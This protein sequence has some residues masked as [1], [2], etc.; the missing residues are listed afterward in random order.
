VKLDLTSCLVVGISSRALFDLTEANEIFDTKGLQA[1]RH[2]QRQ[3]EDD[4]LGQG[5]A[6]PLVKALLRLNEYSQQQRLVEVIV[7]SRNSPDTG[8][9]ILNSIKHYDLDIT[10]AAFTGGESFT[11]YLE[12]YHVDLFLS[13]S[14]EDV[15]GAIDTGFAAALLYDP[16]EDFNPQE[17]QI[18]IA[19]DADAVVFS[20]ESE[21]IYQTQGL[22][23]FETH[24][25]KKAK[26][27]LAEGPFAKLLKTLSFLQTSVQ[28]EEPPVRLA[29]VTA[30]S[31]PA[32]ERVI[33]T[34][35]EWNVYVDEAFFL[36]GLPKEHVL[37]SFG[38]HIFFD[39][40]ES[41]LDTA[42]RVVPS[43]RV[44]Y[45]SKALA[46]K[47][48]PKNP[49]KQSRAA[50]LAKPFQETGEVDVSGKTIFTLTDE[51][52]TASG[53]PQGW[54]FLV[55]KGSKTCGDKRL[56]ASL[57]PPLRAIRQ[58]LIGDG[59]MVPDSDGYR[60]TRNIEFNSA[61][62]AASIIT[63]EQRNARTEWIDPEG[64]SLKDYGY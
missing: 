24:E 26:E 6:F 42:S 64:K 1:Y 4:V 54:G 20:D 34:L 5:T 59:K 53:F 62:E 15:Q 47:E 14:E 45:K 63:G 3:H 30:R 12:A 39:D 48:K 32:H 21:L 11:P 27:P 22:S 23:A 33:R 16:P 37:K 36:G 44:P 61:S 56:K 29:I 60:F 50:A 17:N 49:A 28:A 38:A 25:R 19:F 46:K 43:G 58:K 57:S 18:R 51:A 35:R 2:Y 40:Q 41:H 9:R 13:R 10:R 52:V 55:L 31:G 7:M 8:L